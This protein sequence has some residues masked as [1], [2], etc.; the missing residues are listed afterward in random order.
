MTLLTDGEDTGTSTGAGGTVCASALINRIASAN[1]RNSRNIRTSTCC[2][3]P[4]WTGTGHWSARSPNSCRRIYIGAVVLQSSV[5]DHPSC[6]PICSKG[7]CNRWG[8]S[9]PTLTIAVC[10]TIISLWAWCAIHIQ[11]ARTAVG[12]GRTLII[13]CRLM[14]HCCRLLLPI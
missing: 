6:S 10:R 5:F 12:A 9:R 11:G 4:Q 3:T 7:C 1:S 2:A 14:R 8:Y 13:Q